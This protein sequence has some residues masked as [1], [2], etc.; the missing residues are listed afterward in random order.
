MKHASGARM[1]TAEVNS[2]VRNVKLKKFTVKADKKSSVILFIY[3]LN[4]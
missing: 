1:V 2:N 4:G 3:E